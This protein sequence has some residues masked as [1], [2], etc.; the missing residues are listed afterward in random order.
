LHDTLAQE[1]TGMVLQLEAVSTHIDKNNPVRAQEILK[2]AMEQSRTTLAEAR[3]VIDDLRTE[4]F[5]AQSFR[6][7]VREEAA[8]FDSLSG[9]PCE[10][11]IDLVQEMAGVTRQHVLKIISEG[12]NNVAKHANAQ[13]VWMKI[14]E[15]DNGYHLVIEDDGRGFDPEEEREQ[16][17]QYG[18]IGIQERVELLHGNLVID[19]HVGKGTCL[20][21][22]IPLETVG[23]HHV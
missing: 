14:T 11:S 13:S 18:L 6:A 21:I 5:P 2:G 23:E 15:I 19:S 4:P 3:K 1:L 12:L 20:E 7:A 17:G 9:I 10:I 16:Q 22:H 8:R